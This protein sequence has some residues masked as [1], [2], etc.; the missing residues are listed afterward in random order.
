MPLTVTF[1]ST[2]PRLCAGVTTVHMVVEVQLTVVATFEPNLK[3]VASVPRPNPV[4]VTVTL[5]PPALDPVVGVTLV[6]VGG[7]NRKWSCDEIALVPR[8]VVT[9]TSTAPAVAAGDTA[10]IDLAESTLKLAALVEPN[11]TP[12]APVKALP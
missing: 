11:L 9:V 2:V 3:A 6:T 10:V 4:P 7:P 1:R 5:V 8:G 12:A